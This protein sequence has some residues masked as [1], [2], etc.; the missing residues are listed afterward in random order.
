ML[1]LKNRFL[2][3][4]IATVALVF[5]N[6]QAEVE[7]KTQPKPYLSCPILKKRTKD[8]LKYHYVFRSFDRTLSKRTFS[9]YLRF[10]DPGKLFFLQSD[11]D[12][13]KK[14]ENIVGKKIN[15]KDCAFI[16]DI[17]DVYLKR[18]DQSIG[19]SQEILKS[20]ISFE[21]DEYIETD[22][23]KLRWANTPQDLQDRWKKTVKFVMLNMKD[24]GS[25]SVVTTRI[26]KRYELIQKE[27]K[28][29]TSDDINAIF[30]NAFALSLDPHS[31]FLTPVDNA[32]FQIDFSLKLVGVGA[33]LMSPDGYTTVD[34]LVPGG[35]AALDGRLKKGD[36][37]IAVDPG[38]GSGLSDVI[39]MSLDKV[40][41]LIRGKEGSTVTL[42]VMRQNNEGDVQRLHIKLKRALV[43]IK[44][45]EAKSDI[46]KLDG[47]K[48]GVIN[49]PSFY[50]DYKQCQIRPATCRSSANDMFRE[51]NKLTK[52]GVDGI[53]ID[54]R[55]NGGG[56]LSE[57]ERIVSYFIGNPVVT[58]VQD[59]D[60]SVHRL[61]LQS[62]PFYSG[63]LALLISRY[64][65]SA[66]EIFAGAVQDYG[67]GLIIG[68]SRTF[69]KGTVQTVMDIPGS[70]GRQT[71]GAIH[72]TIAKFFR[73]SGKSNQEK[74]IISDVVIP[75]P[76]D[77]FGI[78]EKD[79]D[80]AL[81]YTTIKA[82]PNFTPI[83]KLTPIIPTLQKRSE[84]R[85]SKLPEYK[86]LQA[87]IEKARENQ[88]TLVSLKEKSKDKKKKNKKSIDNSDTQ[89]AFSMQVI[90]PKDYE[91]KESA[92]ILIDS[93]KLLGRTN[94]EARINGYR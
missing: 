39:D 27:S 91:L 16:S 78:G 50:I 90:H 26:K 32:Q 54:L 74:G 56:D 93:T 67:R 12:S 94:W 6:A 35:A 34:A 48:I 36:K 80:Y 77:F 92:H 71:N 57:A 63:P 14:Y 7:A 65:A 51:I 44:E 23:K 87:A 30:L 38:D 62:D 8:F 11:I 49:L 3:S 61:E 82:A 25:R 76:I 68:D 13:F 70:A 66:S 19:Y 89:S 84:K 37:I 83:Q 24:T 46:I 22:R 47:K 43:E 72:V 59:R 2:V 17:Y 79:Y 45:S 20:K 9:N 55:R 4:I 21:T 75:D 85:I 42:V 52:K 18:V 40:V 28:E 73:P 5:P 60:G 33:T 41:Q 86:D 15:S 81:P 64:T 58:Q 31:S 10:L 69:G 29:R 88:N 1:Q 53:V